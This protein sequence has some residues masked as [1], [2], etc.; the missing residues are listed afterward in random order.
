M[1]AQPVEPGMW[2]PQEILSRLPDVDHEQFVAE[3]RQAV[4]A[5]HELR[6][7]RQL[8]GVLR[9]WHLRAAAY[10]QPDYFQR[11]AEAREG[12]EGRFIPA[13]ELLGDRFAE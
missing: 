7:Y 12:A 11:A 2:D 5:A 6:R 4:D 1:T 8:Q 13:A 3:Y 9:L 10:E